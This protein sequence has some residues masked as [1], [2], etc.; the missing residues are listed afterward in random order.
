[1]SQG[2]SDIPVTEK[3]YNSLS[4][5]L[6]RDETGAT[7]SCGTSFPQ[8]IEPSMIGRLC[9]R[10][11]LRALYYLSSTDP[12][13]WTL[14]IDFSQPLATQSYVTTNFQPLNG[15]LTAFSNLTMTSNSLPY[16]NSTTSMTTLNMTTFFKN[17]LNVNDAAACRSLLGLGSLA[18]VSSITSSNVN[19]YV[20]D[21]SIPAAK[22][23]FTPI[24]AGEG[25]NV[26]DIKE[27]YNTAN[28]TGYILLDKGYTIGDGSSGATYTGSAYNA[29]YLK[30]WSSPTTV[31][32]TAN[33]STVVAKG[34]SASNDWNAHKKLS[35]PSGF[36]YLNSSCT[37]KIRYA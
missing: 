11:D 23:N 4:K 8:E 25:Y 16:F 33:T 20:A 3:V 2:Y 5:L 24:T 29:L 1:M 19:T 7:A 28:E 12:V 26:G 13:N 17:L 9:L 27:S 30:L 6:E 36:K 15:N 21:S 35:L 22:L 37:Y 34:S 32:Y 18:I 10:T 14:M 31:T